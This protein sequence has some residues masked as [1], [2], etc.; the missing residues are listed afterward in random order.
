MCTNKFLKRIVS[1]ELTDEEL[2]KM[3]DNKKMAQRLHTYTHGI[4]S[5]PITL[6]AILFSAV[7]RKFLPQCL[8]AFPRIDLIRRLAVPYR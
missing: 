2:A 7:I 3:K 4:N 5:D 8:L 6:F 1:P